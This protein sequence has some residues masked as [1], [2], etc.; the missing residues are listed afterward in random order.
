MGSFMYIMLALRRTG[1]KNF[2][3]PPS[4]T[5]VADRGWRRE[6]PKEK[7]VLRTFDACTHHY[8]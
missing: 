6:E 8:A 7:T 2:G 4:G 1:V 5:M 3:L